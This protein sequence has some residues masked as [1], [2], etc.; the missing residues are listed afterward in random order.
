MYEK[1]DKQSRFESLDVKSSETQKIGIQVL[2]RKIA[3]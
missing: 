2:R 3:L 1:D